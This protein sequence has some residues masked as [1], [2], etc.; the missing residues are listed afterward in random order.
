MST[1]TT[2]AI[3]GRVFDMQTAESAALAEKWIKDNLGDTTKFHETFPNAVRIAEVGGSRG[4]A[5]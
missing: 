4:I 5:S 3:H 2:I 1:K